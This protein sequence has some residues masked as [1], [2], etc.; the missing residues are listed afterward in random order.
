[1]S[2]KPARN[3]LCHCGSGRK[4]KKCHNLIDH[5]ADRQSTIAKH[6]RIAREAEESRKAWEKRGEELMRQG[7][8]V[9]PRRGRLGALTALA[10]VGAVMP[11]KP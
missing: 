3:E 4:F 2:G 10:M 1:M 5:E 9:G 11:P 8:V 7:H 6:E